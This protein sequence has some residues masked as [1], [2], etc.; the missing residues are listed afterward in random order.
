MA[1]EFVC[2]CGK[3]IRVADEMSG[4]RVRC[5]G[6][7][8]V[9]TVP[10]GGEGEGESEDE[11]EEDASPRRRSKVGAKKKSSLM[12]WVGLGGGVLLLSCCCLGGIGAAF[13]LLFAAP[14][15][16]VLAGNFPIEEKGSWSF[17]DAKTEVSEGLK[18][19]VRA[20]YKGYKVP[21]KANTTYVI[22]LLKAGG[23]CD[24]Y[25][26]LQDPEGKTVA[27]ND[28]VAFNNLDSRITYTPTKD[29]DYR[30]LAA[31]IKGTG[32]FT[33]KI[34]TIKTLLE[35]KGTWTNG[36]PVHPTTHSPQKTY[37]VNLKAGK[38]YTIDLI[39]NVPGQDPFL[40]LTNSTGQVLAQDD[41]G[42]GFP[43]ARI[44][45]F[46]AQDGEY[47]IIATSINRALG[48]FTLTVREGLK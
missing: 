35:E 5:P 32:D 3:K 12:L 14:G 28:D 44:I 8:N 10:T 24:P 29:G 18:R 42:G 19:G 15:D 36:D 34:A 33:L 1:I 13:F 40:F 31:T 2:E 30:I 6:C 20:S 38:K 26:V 46:P 17:G 9:M 22:D 4:K 16:K 47:R 21:L 27:A 25:L 43:N 11:G 41:D 39:S 45:F 37:K 48:S 7:Q 23:D